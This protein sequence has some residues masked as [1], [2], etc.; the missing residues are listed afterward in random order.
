MFEFAIIVVMSL[1]WR[2]IHARLLLYVQIAMVTSTVYGNATT[3]IAFCMSYCD[4]SER[5]R[6]WPCLFINAYA[7]MSGNDDSVRGRAQGHL[8]DSSGEGL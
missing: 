3:L 5:R 1:L 4:D 7:V 2:R 6:S 8:R